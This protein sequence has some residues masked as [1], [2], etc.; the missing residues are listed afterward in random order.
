MK[1]LDRRRFWETAELENGACGVLC[2]FAPRE[3]WNGLPIRQGF[4]QF[5]GE[6]VQLAA[7]L[8]DVQAAYP[9]EV[10]LRNADR[11]KTIFGLSW[12]AAGDVEVVN[13]FPGG[14]HELPQ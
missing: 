5:R 8:D 13:L 2:K 11:T 4:R 6:F 7:D 10:I 9:G 3:S 14:A 12:I 1:E